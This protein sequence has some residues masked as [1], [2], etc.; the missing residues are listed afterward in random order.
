MR[1]KP[2][3]IFF[4]LFFS[5]SKYPRFPIVEGGLEKHCFFVFTKTKRLKGNVNGHMFNPSHL[6]YCSSMAQSTPS[7]SSR[8]DFFPATCFKRYS[9]SVFIF[10]LKLY[11]S[12]TLYLQMHLFL[13]RVKSFWLIFQSAFHNFASSVVCKIHTF[14]RTSCDFDSCS[15]QVSVTTNSSASTSTSASAASSSG[16]STWMHWRRDSRRH[17]SIIHSGDTVV[18]Q[19]KRKLKKLSIAAINVNLTNMK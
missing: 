18:I 2:F 4:K 3:W 13:L 7:N 16:S 12:L 10:Q 19:L 11:S 1:Q 9:F 8:D 5:Q 15:N 14:V 6:K 17:E